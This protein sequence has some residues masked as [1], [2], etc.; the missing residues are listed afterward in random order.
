VGREEERGCSRNGQEGM[1]VR[2]RVCEGKGVGGPGE[3]GL[4]W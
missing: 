2:R 1:S 3:N 4:Y